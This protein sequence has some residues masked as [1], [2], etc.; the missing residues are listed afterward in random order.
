MEVT[1]NHS[2]LKIIAISILLVAVVFIMKTPED[3]MKIPD[4]IRCS[5]IL[6][7]TKEEA[8][9]II[10]QLNNGA[11][12]AGLA[13]EKSLCPSKNKGGDLGE[14]EKGAMVK[15]FE[16]ASFNLKKGEISD[17]VQTQFGWHVIKRI[18]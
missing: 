13:M 12:F 11:D 1:I 3:S 2:I 4:K 15:E 17:P 8:V 7:E 10:D 18:A 6:V 9:Q 5:H 16:T 14:F